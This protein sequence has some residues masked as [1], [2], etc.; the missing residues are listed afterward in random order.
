LD[1]LDAGHDEV[2]DLVFLDNDETVAGDVVGCFR[3]EA[4]IHKPT[5]IRAEIHQPSWTARLPPTVS[6][7]GDFRQVQVCKLGFRDQVQPLA[8]P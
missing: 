6:L 1:R 7:S 4:S 8:E 3:S 2:F 5:V